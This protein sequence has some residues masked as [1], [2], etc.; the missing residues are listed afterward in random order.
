[1]FKSELYR[2]IKKLEA[3]IRKLEASKAKAEM[4]R[5]DVTTK[6]LAEIEEALCIGVFIGKRKL[7]TRLLKAEAKLQKVRDAEAEEDA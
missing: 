7:E 2:D 3:H 1:M 6:L 4:E 5:A